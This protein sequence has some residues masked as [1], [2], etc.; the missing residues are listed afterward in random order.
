MV[1]SR[2]HSEF[3]NVLEKI[4]FG[5]TPEDIVRIKND[6]KNLFCPDCMQDIFFDVLDEIMQ[7]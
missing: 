2:C 6:E 3:E 4:E 5:L 1:C 7:S